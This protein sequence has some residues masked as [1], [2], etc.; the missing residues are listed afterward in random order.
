MSK[1]K[2]L[3]NTKHLDLYANRRITSKGWEIFCKSPFTCNIED[4]DIGKTEL[5]DEDLKKL[6]DGNFSKLETLT[7]N[8]CP[9][10]TIKGF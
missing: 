1:S 2:Y 6:V 3:K 5:T 9:K 8:E 4:I 10:L 7:L